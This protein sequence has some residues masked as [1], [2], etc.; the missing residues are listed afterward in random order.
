MWQNGL[1]HK[2][3]KTDEYILPYPK[4]IFSIMADNSDKIMSNVGASML[5]III[6]LIF[7]SVLGY[8]AAIGATVSP[9]FG[10]GGLTVIRSAQSI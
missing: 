4:R 8:A 7:G 5:V 2:L 3:L 10:K 1:M 6:G 9:K